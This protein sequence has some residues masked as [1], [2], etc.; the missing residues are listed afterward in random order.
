MPEV[1][2]RCVDRVAPRLCEMGS[3]QVVRCDELGAAG[4]LLIIESEMRTFVEYFE[5]ELRELDYGFVVPLHSFVET[6]IKPGAGKTAS[7]AAMN[8]KGVLVR[9][10][11]EEDGKPHIHVIHEGKWRLLSSSSLRKT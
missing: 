5:D 2:A 3:K 4:T 9:Y 6:R 7:Q 8:I 10:I 11:V 1:A